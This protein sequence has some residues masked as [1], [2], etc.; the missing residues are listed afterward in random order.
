MT[1]QPSIL[2]RVQRSGFTLIELVVVLI[3]LTVV[4][5]LAAPRMM[6]TQRREL[7]VTVE[8]IADL[9][10]IAAYRDAIGGRNV[11]IRFDEESRTLHL[12]VRELGEGEWRED[13]MTPGVPL[14]NLHIEELTIGY[15]APAG[16]DRE[17]WQVAFPAAEPRPAIVMMLQPDAR[18]ESLAWTIRLPAYATSA[19]V[20]RPG[21][22]VP[23]GLDPIDLDRAGL[24]DVA[25]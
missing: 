21:D 7:D 6:Q 1:S 16:P 11:A 24:E 9:L 14:G 10:S 20:Q 12:M 13:P 25:W 17:A 15:A 19:H 5:G 4:V 3:M 18:N 2:A 8:R 23:V 22:P